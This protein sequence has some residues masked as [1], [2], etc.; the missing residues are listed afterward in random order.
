MNF[1]TLK[2]IPATAVIIQVNV[3]FEN[4]SFKINITKN[5]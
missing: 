4:F 1:P 3:I 2:W 5:L